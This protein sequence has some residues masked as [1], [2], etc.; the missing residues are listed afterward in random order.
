MFTSRF[1]PMVRPFF[2]H[3][4]PKFAK[5]EEVV[6]LFSD[7]PINVKNISPLKVWEAVQAKRKGKSHCTV[8]NDFQSK[9]GGSQA[10]MAEQAD[11]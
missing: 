7:D 4:S 10:T 9:G 6:T 1:A 5:E 8:G 3:Y 2:F 11:N